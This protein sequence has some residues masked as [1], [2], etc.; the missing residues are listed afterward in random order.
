MI[1]VGKKKKKTPSLSPPPPQPDTEFGIRM[2][3]LVINDKYRKKVF[4]KIDLAY[5][6]YKERNGPITKE[7]FII[8]LRIRSWF[9]FDDEVPDIKRIMKDAEK[10]E[11][12]DQP[13]L[14]EEQRKDI[15]DKIFDRLS[16]RG[17]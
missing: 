8:L 12:E 5:D 4:D 17:W 16:K 7:E 14:W 10:E 11:E 6:K 9:N 15:L 13:I 1:F 2:A 3:K